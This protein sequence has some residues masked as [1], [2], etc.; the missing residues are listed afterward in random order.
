[1]YTP[2]KYKCHTDINVNKETVL[3][4]VVLAWL[5]S[6]RPWP[7]TVRP[8]P[9]ISASRPRPNVSDCYS[10]GYWFE[11]HLHSVRCHLCQA[12]QST[13]RWCEKSCKVCNRSFSGGSQQRYLAAVRFLLCCLGTMF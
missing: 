8:K 4:P 3:M 1:M 13:C 2:L 6:T 10:Y 12:W 11:L 9:R 5:Q 7:G